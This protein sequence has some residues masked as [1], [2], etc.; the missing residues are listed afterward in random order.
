MATDKYLNSTLDAGGRVL[1]PKGFPAHKMVLTGTYEKTAADTDTSIL[2]VGKVPANAIPDY[3]SSLINNDAL[4]GA[5]DVDIGIYK[6]DKG[7]VVDKDLLSDGLNIAAGNALTSPIKAFQTH[8]A[9]DEF[10]LTLLELTNLTNTTTRTDQEFDIALTGNTF[11]TA[12]G[13][14]TWRLEFIV[15]QMG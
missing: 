15:P 9:I 1:T 3:H 14:I 6:A 11:G 2:R 5:T 13:T 8:P 7:A 4:A 10:G 12:T